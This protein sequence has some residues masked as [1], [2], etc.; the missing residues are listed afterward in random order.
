L[1]ESRPSARTLDDDDSWPDDLDQAA[2]D[3]LQALQWQL[4][5]LR[6]N[7]LKPVG[8]K[9]RRA[10]F[11]ARGRIFA[12]IT[13]V[14]SPQP[15]VISRALA[16][17]TAGDTASPSPVESPPGDAG[18]DSSSEQALDE[19][20]KASLTQW[21]ELD[22]GA[23]WSAA[24]A[25]AHVSESIVEQVMLLT[26]LQAILPSGGTSSVVDSTPPDHTLQADPIAMIAAVSQVATSPDPVDIYTNCSQLTTAGFEASKEFTTG[27][28]LLA[29]ASVAPAQV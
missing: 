5:M 15:Y 26:Y 14:R 18:T 19:A 2:A 24:I 27:A 20:L 9:A 21:A 25:Y 28:A 29:L 6:L 12:A 17:A 4:G 23:F 11:A 8:W 22:L 16:L 3:L 1:T 13:G 7:Y 10:V